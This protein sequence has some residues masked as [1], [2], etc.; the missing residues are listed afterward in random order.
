MRFISGEVCSSL[1]IVG[2]KWLEASL[3]YAFEK[4]ELHQ[5]LARLT[6]QCSPEILL[7]PGGQKYRNSCPLGV[8]PKTSKHHSPYPTPNHTNTH[9]LFPRLQLLFFSW[10]RFFFSSHTDNLNFF[11]QYFWASGTAFF[12]AGSYHEFL[13]QIRTY[14]Y[15]SFLLYSFSCCHAVTVEFK[16]VMHLDRQFLWKIQ[17]K[18][19]SQHI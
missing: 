7:V 1:K 3:Q 10:L 5:S 18:I 16:S 17:M 15:F 13:L 8:F 2:K 14:Y 9:T 11:C 4:T 6:A 19:E 12:L